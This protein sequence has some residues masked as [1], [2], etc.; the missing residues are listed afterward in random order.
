MGEGIDCIFT[1]CGD[2]LMNGKEYKKVYCQF[3]EYYGD[4]ERHYYCAVREEAYQVFIMEEE[5]AEEKLLYDFSRPG[6]TITLNHDG[7]KFARTGGW[8]RFEFLPGQLVYNVCKY[9]EDGYVDKVHDSTYWIDGVGATLNNPFAFELR[10]LPFDEPKFG[11][12]IIV[13]TC[14]KEGK[15]IFMDE[16]MAEPTK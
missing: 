11:K 4:K 14:M 1:M 9:T 12:E 15:H 10:F 7:F 3:E 16:W 8:H 2:T 5:A 13:R 6:E